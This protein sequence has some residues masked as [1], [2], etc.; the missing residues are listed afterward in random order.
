MD[1]IYDNYDRECLPTTYLRVGSKINP[2]LGF[3]PNEEGYG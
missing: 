3:V 1:E 2:L